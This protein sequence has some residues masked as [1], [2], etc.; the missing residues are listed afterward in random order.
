M[1]QQNKIILFIITMF[2]LSSVYLFIV[3]EKNMD[4]DYK[5]N[6]WI[7]YFENPSSDS[8][9][10]VI[11]NHSQK[12]NFHWEVWVGDEKMQEADFA[13]PKGQKKGFMA[14]V[15]NLGDKKITIMVSD[16]ENKKEIYKSF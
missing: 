3:S 15:Q 8:T 4:A 1:R 12:S 2:I 6:W 13:I 5:K 11:E 14:G 16:G 10:F 7:L 9:N